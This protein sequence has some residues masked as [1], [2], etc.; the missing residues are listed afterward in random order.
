MSKKKIIESDLS[1]LNPHLKWGS[2]VHKMRARAFAD[3]EKDAIKA[4][5]RWPEF[6]GEFNASKIP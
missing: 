3:Y 1:S 4:K 5:A 2:D 6:W